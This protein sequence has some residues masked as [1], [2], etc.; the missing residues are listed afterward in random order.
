[1]NWNWSPL[2]TDAVIDGA[3]SGNSTLRDGGVDGSGDV[4]FCSQPNQVTKPSTKRQSTRGRVRRYVK[5]NSSAEGKISASKVRM[6]AGL[7]LPF[8]FD[9]VAD[10]GPDSNLMIPQQ[11][12]ERFTGTLRSHHDIPSR[13]HMAFHTPSL[14]RLSILSRKP[15]IIQLMAGLAA[16]GE[17]FRLAS[18][19]LMRV[20]TVH[21]GQCSTLLVTTTPHQSSQLIGAVGVI[22][23]PDS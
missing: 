2:G 8:L 13:R 23:A 4:V 16:F 10:I 19:L 3:S 18:L 12:H 7:R 6:S 20:V 15:A 17:D 9:G 1:M 21:A 5:L 11:W 14:Q 22:V